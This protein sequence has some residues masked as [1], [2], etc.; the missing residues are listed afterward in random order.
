MS[1]ASNNISLP[2]NDE[3]TYPL[4]HLELY[5]Q[6]YRLPTYSNPNRHL[7]P[8]CNL[9]IVIMAFALCQ[10]TIYLYDDQMELGKWTTLW[11]G[12]RRKRGRY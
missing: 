6:R 12:K 1:A 7:Y 9:K 11:N 4:S 3:L 8:L 2:V 10:F 5:P